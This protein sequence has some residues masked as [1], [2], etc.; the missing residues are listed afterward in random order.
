[1]ALTSK[2]T[3]FLWFPHPFALTAAEFYVSLFNSSPS[4]HTSKSAIVSK[5]TYTKSTTQ[6]LEAHK[7]TPRHPPAGSVLIVQFSLCGQNFLALNGPYLPD[8]PQNSLFPF[9]EAISFSI[10][11]ETQ[12]EID[13]YWDGL[14][15][16][17]GKTIDCGWCKDKFGVAWQVVPRRLRE[18]MDPDGEGAE[19]CGMVREMVAGAMMK[20]KKMEIEALEDAAKEAREKI[21]KIQARQQHKKF[22]PEHSI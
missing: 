3:P 19:A 17:G 8:Q 5:S 15:K 9:N 14:T 20:M 1:M 10:E 12:E 22:G 2:I 18:L 16:D 11:C 7:D 4:P 13:Y 6:E 21:L